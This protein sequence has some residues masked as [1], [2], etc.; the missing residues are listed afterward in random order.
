MREKKRGRLQHS[1]SLNG[2]DKTPLDRNHEYRKKS[3]TIPEC[4]HRTDM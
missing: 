4:A 1:I 3:L 2:C